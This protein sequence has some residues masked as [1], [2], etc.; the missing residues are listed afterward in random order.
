MTSADRGADPAPA[1][2]GVDLGGTKILARWID[3]VTG[4][5]QGRHKA[6]T[7]TTG[8]ADVLEADEENA[9]IL[10]WRDENG[11]LVD[12]GFHGTTG[13]DG[14]GEAVSMGCVRLRNEDVQVLHD[15]L[16]LDAEVTV[17]L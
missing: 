3:P 8:P 1:F 13:A 12:V 10:A 17:Q 5:A 4:R 2:I 14:V 6:V 15:T 9:R 7:P 11:R 16:P